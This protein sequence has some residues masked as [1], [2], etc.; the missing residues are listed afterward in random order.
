VGEVERADRF[1]DSNA[2][3]VFNRGNALGVGGGGR[4]VKYL[5]SGFIV[6]I[7]QGVGVAPTEALRSL[8]GLTSIGTE[9]KLT[10]CPGRYG[11]VV[12]NGSVL[13]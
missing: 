2:G 10:G 1:L 4:G 8:N 9:S 6:F 13:S 3:D 7:S 5:S 11:H 12:V